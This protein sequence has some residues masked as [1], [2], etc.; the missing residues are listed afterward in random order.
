M[1]DPVFTF[2]VA[3]DDP[4]DPGWVDAGIENLECRYPQLLKRD[5]GLLFR[6]VNLN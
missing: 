4:S 6:F 1:L 2:S 3:H 5:T